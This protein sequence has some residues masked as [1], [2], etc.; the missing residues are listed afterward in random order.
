[1]PLWMPGAHTHFQCYLNCRVFVW[2]YF[3]LHYLTVQILMINTFPN[4][5][6]IPNSNPAR[7]RARRQGL[8]CQTRDVTAICRGK[9]KSEHKRPIA[10]PVAICRGAASQPWGP[11]QCWRYKS[12]FFFPLNSALNKNGRETRRP[13]GLLWPLCIQAGCVQL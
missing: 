1:M 9:K 5:Q 7:D 6:M 8:S 11:W 12:S 13:S 4:P 2:L 10:T 3:N